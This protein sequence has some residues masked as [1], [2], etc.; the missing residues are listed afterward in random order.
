MRPA[1]SKEKRNKRRAQTKKAGFRDPSVARDNYPIVFARQ[2]SHPRFVEGIGGE[3]LL[4]VHNLMVGFNRVILTLGELRS[5]VIV[6]KNLTT[7]RAR[8]SPPTR[9]HHAT[10][11][12]CT[13]M[14]SMQRCSACSGIGFH[15][16]REPRRWNANWATIGCPKLRRG[17]MMICRCLPSR[18]QT[19][20]SPR[21]FKLLPKLVDQLQNSLCSVTRSTG[22]HLLLLS[23]QEDALSIPPPPP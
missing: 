7:S 15:T 3:A 5:G 14:P 22:L 13:S 17:S 1:G 10:S 4:Q 2:G 21:K 18:N 19:I 23:P 12:G 8:V 9:P 20:S 16:A 6:G 11:G